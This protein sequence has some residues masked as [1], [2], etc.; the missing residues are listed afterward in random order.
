MPKATRTRLIHSSHPT[1]VALSKRQFALPDQHSQRL[2]SNHTPPTSSANEILQELNDPKAYVS[3][4]STKTTKQNPA[5]Q[6]RARDTVQPYSK[7]HGKRLKKKAKEQAVVGDLTPVRQALE[8]VLASSSAVW[9]PL[10]I[11]QSHL[12]PTCTASSQATHLKNPTISKK[13]ISHK[14]KAKLLHE[15]A[16]R[17]PSILKH[18]SSEKIRLRLSAPIFKTHPLSNPPDSVMLNCLSLIIF[19]YNLS[20]QYS[21][22]Y[23]PTRDPRTGA[24]HRRLNGTHRQFLL[25]PKRHA[26]QHHEVVCSNPSVVAFASQPS[27]TQSLGVSPR[28]CVSPGVKGFALRDIA[29][30]RNASPAMQMPSRFLWSYR[31]SLRAFPPRPLRGRKLQ[32]VL[33]NDAL[34]YYRYQCPWC[35]VKSSEK[36]Q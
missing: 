36:Y 10:T 18:P 22:I 32:W 29:S 9:P 11:I 27:V 35:Y 4:N 5:R 8:E 16:T 13:S 3:S 21:Y 6:F 24:L 1:A 15:E 12:V 30:Q 31:F 17:L 34:K 20:S 19:A 14:Q 26:C 2:L 28:V 23:S 25:Q 7:S 33:C